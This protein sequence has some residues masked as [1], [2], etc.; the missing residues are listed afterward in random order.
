M[1]TF[2]TKTFPPNK[3]F[4]HKKLYQVLVDNFHQNA[5]SEIQRPDSKL[6]YYSTFKTVCGTEMYMNKVNNIKH[7]IALSRFRLSCHKLNIELGRYTRIPRE[8]RYCPFCPNVVEDENHFLFNC[9]A[10]ITERNLLFQTVQSYTPL[11]K[12]YTQEIKLLCLMTREETIPQ[13]AKFIFKAFEIREH[14]HPS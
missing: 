13:V 3:Y 9:D 11:F 14:L 1:S 7:R 12:F 6:N 5:F 2:F 10:Y 8:E 4:I